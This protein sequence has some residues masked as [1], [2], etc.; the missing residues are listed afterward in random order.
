MIASVKEPA[1]FIESFHS[2]WFHGISIFSHG[3]PPLSGIT[4]VCYRSIL[5]SPELFVTAT[6]PPLLLPPRY[7][8]TARFRA[9]ATTFC[10]F[11]VW[12]VCTRLVGIGIFIGIATIPAT[13][14]IRGRLPVVASLIRGIGDDGRSRFQSEDF[15]ELQS[16]RP[17]TFGLS[18]DYIL[19]RRSWSFCEKIT[20]GIRGKIMHIGFTCRGASKTRAH[21]KKI[22]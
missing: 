5:G 11:N 21:A 15:L 20:K 17:Y 18:R 19:C 13:T 3:S 9:A 7:P 8:F 6:L 4:G 10:R 12:L 1:D 16:R 14:P 2:W 22:Y